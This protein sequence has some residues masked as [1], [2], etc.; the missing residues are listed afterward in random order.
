MKYL[1]AALVSE[2]LKRLTSWGE[3]F[4]LGT[5]ALSYLALEDLDDTSA[6]SVDRLNDLI[7]ERRE[8][9]EKTSA[10]RTPELICEP[11]DLVS[12]GSA[13]VQPNFI[14]ANVAES[15]VRVLS[16]EIKHREELSGKIVLIEN[17]DPGFDWI[18]TRQIAGFI[19]AYGGENSHM[20]IRAREFSMPAAIG[21]GDQMFRALSQA[22]KV[23]LDC[24]TR[25]IQILQ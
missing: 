20:S 3:A 4:G 7:Q 10:L 23:R 12:F 11:K 17:A 13:M 21:V 5:D 19:T 15:R 16:P 22:G 2:A 1:Y 14:T 8:S 18:F 9:W 25:K 24:A 6:H